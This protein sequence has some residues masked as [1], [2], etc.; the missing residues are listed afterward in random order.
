MIATGITRRSLALAVVALALA[1]LAPVAAQASFGL[2]PGDEGFNVS[3]KGEGGKAETTLAGAHPYSLVTELNF[4]KAGVFSDGDLR[5]LSLDLPPGLIENATA[6][7]KCTATLFTTAR[8]SPFESSLSG[9]SCPDTTQLGTVTLK[10]SHAGGETRTFGVFNLVPPPGFP[11][12]FGFSA[13]GVPVTVI[14]H[15]R[16]ADREYGLTLDLKNFS[17][18]LNFTGF[19]LEIWGTPWALPHNFQRGNCLNEAEP[20]FGWGKCSV[21]NKSPEHVAQ[22]YLT[23]PTSCGSG[24][25]FHASLSSWQAPGVVERTFTTP[26]P[27]TGCGELPFAPIPSARLSTDRTTSTTGFDFTLDGSSK[28]LLDPQLRA[29]SQAKKAVVRLAEGMTVNPSVASGLGTCSEGQYATETLNSQPGEGCPNDSKIGELT[30]ESPLVEGRI[31]GSVFFASPRDNRFGT[32]LALYMVAKAPDRGIMVKVAGR[33]D[34]NLATGQLTATFDNLPQLP[35]AHFNVHFREGQRSPLA[36]A[37]AC[38]NYS[39]QIDSSPWLAPDTV[40]SQGSPFSLTAGVGGGLCPQG[41]IAP[42]APK[43]TAGTANSN[44]GSYSPFYLHLTRAD[45]EQEITSYSAQL[46]RGLLG[47]IAHI[48]FCSE[49]QID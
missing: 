22:A 11:S 30:V 25:P 8:K 12:E 31:E 24:L 49:A 42:F 20:T 4:N 17:Q 27:L 3:L 1:L 35:Y 15:V 7:P 37:S 46:P 41:P 9:E 28:Q 38:G 5:N 23:L 19:R 32:L 16:E 14:P 48:P 43:A 6:V 21:L 47:S 44:A 45:N 2:L 39:T 34:S 18:Q 13:Y 33:V 26:K 36:T 10:S 40:L 29:A